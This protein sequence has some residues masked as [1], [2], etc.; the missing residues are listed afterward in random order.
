M[1]R[2][3]TGFRAWLLQRISAVYLGIFLPAAVLYLLISPPADY[4]G[5]RD[6][7]SQ[8]WVNI[9]LLL[10]SF[11]VL[12]HAW[13]GIR[14]IFIDYVKPFGLRLALLVLLGSFLIACG[15]WMILVL[16]PLVIST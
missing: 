15:F 1:S 2:H 3:M 8:P 16:L 11:S 14:D 6:T 9:S 13:V 10:F 7:L 4:Q 12:L 5:W